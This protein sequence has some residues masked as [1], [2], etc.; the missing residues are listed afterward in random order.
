M[1]GTH[2]PQA[3]K[4]IDDDHFNS[5]SNTPQTL[6]GPTMG[7]KHDPSEKLIV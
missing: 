3:E 4:A 1:H 7:P 2:S 5:R 6:I